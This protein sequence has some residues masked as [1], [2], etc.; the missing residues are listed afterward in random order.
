MPSLKALRPPGPMLLL[1]VFFAGF[2]A[3]ARCFVSEIDPISVVRFSLSIV[4]TVLSGEGIWAIDL[5]VFGRRWTGG[6][7]ACSLE[8]IT[9]IP[10]IK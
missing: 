5:R 1:L 2:S 8:A 3:M 10:R 9:L 4:V 6:V 7:V